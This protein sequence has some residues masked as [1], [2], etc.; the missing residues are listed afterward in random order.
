M[1]KNIVAKVATSLV[2][3]FVAVVWAIASRSGIRRGGL[4]VIQGSG[5]IVS[6][7]IQ[8]S[9]FT[10][11][12]VGGGYKLTFRQSD[13]FSVVLKI[14]ENLIQYLR[15]SVTDGL[16]HLNS[17]EDFQVGDDDRPHLSITAPDLTL[18]VFS[19]S[20]NADMDLNVENLQITTAGASKMTLSGSADI[21][22]ISTAGATKIKAFGMTA[23]DVSI[24]TAGSGKAEI[25]VTDTLHV[26][27]AG[28]RKIVYDG[29]PQVKQSIAGVGTIERRSN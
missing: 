2:L 18:V 19:G 22:K 11:I 17:D 1:A 4:N 15:T 10:G 6:H 29:E 13:D 25:C 8:A 7:E 28:S 27:I 23:R 24:K 16:F 26:N 3:G 21:L 12:N 9:G 5:N 14:H 20:I